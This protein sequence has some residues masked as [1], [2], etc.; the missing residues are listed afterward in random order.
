M[1]IMVRLLLGIIVVAYPFV[2]Y[3]GLLHFQFWQVA[4]F[5]IVIA[6]LRLLVV[7]NQA[8]NYL[9]IGFFGAVLLLFF[10]A[11]ALLFKQQFW[12]KF[13]PIAIS[14]AML[15][16]F[17]SSLWTDKNMVQRFAEI[18]EKNI[19]IEK[20]LYMRKL[21]Q[22]WCGFFIFNAMVSS[23]TM[24]FSSDKHWMLYNGLVS[25]IL[26]GVLGL[27]ELIYRHVVVLRR[28]S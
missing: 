1:K 14:L 10:A 12:F 20:Q 5:V 19:T 3:F 25:Y 6:M 11:M 18:R 8:S 26:M 13:Y 2:V 24:L 21:T 15:Y 17:A 23:Y 22:V 4:V 16:F 28:L 27:S 7:K 9:K